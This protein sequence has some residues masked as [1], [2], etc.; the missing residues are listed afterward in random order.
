MKKILMAFL[1]SGTFINA[2]EYPNNFRN[3]LGI[4]NYLSGNFGELR[5]F[6]FH[7]GL[8]IKTNQRE[9]YN[10]YAIEDGYV[11]RINVSP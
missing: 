7:S 2:Q 1:I 4:E 6:H 10:I 3:P 11:S 9:G 5:G 8:D